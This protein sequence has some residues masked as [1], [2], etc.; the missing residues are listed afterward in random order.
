[1]E[2]EVLKLDNLGR[3]IT[4]INDKICFIENA[5]PT[6]IIEIEITKETSKYIEA[7]VIK[8]IKKSPL[9]IE[10]ECPYSNICGGCNLNHMCFNEENKFKLDKV[11]SIMKKYANIDTNLVEGIIYHDRNN[12]RNKLTMH[13]KDNEIGLYKEKSNEIIP[14]QSC[15]IVNP[16]INEIIK[17][18]NNTTKK[19]NKI[20]I[21]TSNDNS[22]IML[23]IDGSIDNIDILKK[24]CSVLILN[25]Q[26]ILENKTIE[27]NIGNKK[28]LEGIDSFFQI[29]NTLTKELY[30][31]VLINVKDKK[32][33]TILD[34]YCGTGTIGI[35]VSDYVKE[36]IGIDY[37]ESNIDDANKNKDLNN[38]NNIRFICDKVE[39][40]I[41]TFNDI[42][43]VIV[44]PPRA[45]LDEK[46]RKY[47]KEI[48][49]KEII[50]V[51]CDPITL[52]RDIKD[53]DTYK[54]KYIKVFNMF[55][56]TYHIESLLVLEKKDA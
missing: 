43:L 22:K 15:L 23:K 51:S 20:I 21:K 29:N 17:L 12:Y 3:G 27:T 25:D 46:T 36:V 6:E 44:D 38:V 2:V 5:L 16:K 28:Y 54:V 41:D 40:K 18:L 34:L 26:Y 35:Y 14:I 50:Y 55:P 8:Y 10:E 24:L 56:R 30:D 49:S 32:Y 37:N 48:N 33:K 19:V 53:L 47:L 11:K 42:D 13:G 31:E 39:N 7:K 52:A 9:R 4:Y 1:M 45:G